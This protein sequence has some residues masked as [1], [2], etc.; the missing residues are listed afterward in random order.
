MEDRASMLCARVMRGISSMA[1]K[2]TPRSASAR[3]ASPAVSGSP[4]PMAVCPCRNSAR[5]AAPVSGFAPGLRTCKITSAVRNTS[6]RL[7]ARR[8]PFS[9][10]SASGKPASPP[11]PGCMSNSTPVL[12]K[13][14][15]ALGTI[16]TRRSPGDPSATI[17]TIIP[18]IVPK[19][20]LPHGRGSVREARDANQS[21][22][23]EGA[24]SRLQQF[25]RPKEKRQLH[26]R[27]LRAVRPV[28]AIPLDVGGE[29]LADGAFGGISRVGGAH[30][31]AQT[32]DGILALQRH[33]DNR[34]LGHE[35]DQAA[36]E[37]ALLMDRVETLGLLFGEPCHAQAQNLKARLLNQGQN[38]TCL[39]GCHGIG[40]NNGKRT[41]DTHKRLCTFT[42][43]SAGVGQTVMPASSMALIL[44]DALPLPPAII[45]P[46]CP[47]RR[48]GGAVWPATKPITGLVTL[49]LI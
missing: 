29:P 4:K 30:H 1:R 2:V 25:R 45:A 43:K 41:F 20:P 35:L 39:P 6:S 11:A 10:Y 28:N 18:T 16:A 9:T 42:P 26:R 7:P 38:F 12:F 13:T 31:F 34:P 15:M 40:L 21:R 5:S 22:D 27:R 37:G 49:A 32:L 19:K 36:I 47:M 33:H 3:A 23:R 8:T 44:S 14:E 48:P 17:P 24:V 46:A